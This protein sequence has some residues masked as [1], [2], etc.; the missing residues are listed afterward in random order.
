M[1]GI[2]FYQE[3]SDKS[4]RTSAGTIIAALVCNGLYWSSGKVCY[5]DIAGLFDRPNS[6]VAGTGVAR[7]YLR[8]KCKRISEANARTIHP[9]LF[10]RFDQPQIW[11]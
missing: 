10:E 5:E 3:F 1:S 4:K 8:Q 6:L 2:C 7:D 9:A 11:T